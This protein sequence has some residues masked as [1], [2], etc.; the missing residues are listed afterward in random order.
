[1]KKI[2]NKLFLIVLLSFL[3][4]PFFPKN[5]VLAATD[6]SRLAGQEGPHAHDA[7]GYLR[8]PAARFTGNT[9]TS[10]NQVLDVS[11]R[12][13]CRYVV[14]WCADVVG[15]GCEETYPEQNCS[16]APPACNTPDTIPQSD[17]GKI[18]GRITPPNT[19]D[20]FGFGS[21][22][23]SKF[24]SNIVALIFTV[25]IIVF[26]FMILWGSFD[27]LMSGGDKEKISSSQKKII[28]A[29][30]GILLFAMAFAIIRILG[31]FTGFTFFK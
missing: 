11:C 23:I 8:N 12:G 27:W 21:V 4:I 13:G 17:I 6:C 24:L 18:F 19:L 26:V 7:D 2:I 16:T 10:R 15:T 9:C 14:T 3:F 5:E 1:M 29:I 20:Q 31:A 25:A 28:N 22:G 30:I